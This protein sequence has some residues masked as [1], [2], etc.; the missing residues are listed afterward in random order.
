[1]KLL[2]KLLQIESLKLNH[3]IHDSRRIENEI[4]NYLC[5]ATGEG[6]KEKP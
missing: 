1:M 6:L 4:Y 5:D 3:T 2:M